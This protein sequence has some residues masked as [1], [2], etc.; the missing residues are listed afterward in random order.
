MKIFWFGMAIFS[1][2]F[3]AWSILSGVEDVF[4]SVMWA[5][6]CIAA[7]IWVSTEDM[8][9]GNPAHFYDPYDPT[10][11]LDTEEAIDEYIKAAQEDGDPELIAAALRDINRARWRN[12]IYD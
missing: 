10:N 7:A 12:G 9:F 11:L 2:S 5:F 1:M 6:I 8:H 4:L 3:V